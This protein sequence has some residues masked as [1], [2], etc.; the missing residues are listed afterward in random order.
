MTEATAPGRRLQID[1]WA[2]I[3]CPW[4]YLGET[5]LEKAIAESPH[6]DS[7]DLFLHS[8]ELDPNLPAEPR[9]VP[10]Y[11][12]ERLGVTTEQVL[13][14]ESRMAEMAAE[15]GLPYRAERP[16]ANSFDVHRVV[17]FA[18]GYGLAPRLFHA[19]QL[20]LF[21]GAPD[22]YD[23]GRITEVAVEVGLDAARV[24]EV[25]AGDEYADAVRDDERQAAELGVTGVPFTVFDGRL[26]LPGA[27]SARDYAA[28]VAR[29]W[30]GD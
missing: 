5:R 21:G 1:V 26:A 6:A 30:A 13:R 27:A 12:A 15:E 3:G 17:Q 11:L 23:H 16:H 22:A 24:R 7:I 2:D 28:V 10:E 20:T 18:A 14:M 25:L 29:A 19:L 4:C 9:P 8:F